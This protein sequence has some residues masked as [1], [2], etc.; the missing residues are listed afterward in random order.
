NAIEHG[1]GTFDTLAQFG[2]IFLLFLVGLSLN[3]SHIKHIGKV[4]TITGLAQVVFTATIGYGILRLLG[5]TSMPALYM[6]LALT[7]SSTII[8]VKLLTDKRDTETVYGRHVLGLMI[9]QDI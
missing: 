1:G 6:A 2:I 7:F 4:S 8:M 5:F 9:I 3:I